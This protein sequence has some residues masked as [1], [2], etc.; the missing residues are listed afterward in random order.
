MQKEL[1]PELF[2]SFKVSTANLEENM[3]HGGRFVNG[4]D[5]VNA[6]ADDLEQVEI[7][8]AQLNLNVGQLM[9]QMSDIQTQFAELFKNTQTRMDRLQQSIQ[10]LE[11][12]DHMIAQEIATRMNQV[13][14]R[15][16]DRKTQDLKI[17]QMM[18]RHNTKKKSFELRL[19]Q[20]QK[21]LSEKEAQVLQTTAALNEAKMEIARLKRM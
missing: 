1:N 21:V 11:Q 5:G 12:N 13:H 20:A 16:G 6:K 14:T 2:G 15:I 17:Q 7:R 8:V 18:D 10:K 4:N 3:V 9:Q 19:Q